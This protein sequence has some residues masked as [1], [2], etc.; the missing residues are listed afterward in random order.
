MYIV[1][2]KVTIPRHYDPQ[3]LRCNP[4]ISRS[5]LWPTALSRA[6]IHAASPMWGSP[7]HAATTAWFWCCNQIEFKYQ[8]FE[9]TTGL[10]HMNSTPPLFT[11]ASVGLPRQ[12]LNLLRSWG[13][14][15]RRQHRRIWY[16][17]FVE[18]R[19]KRVLEKRRER[20]RGINSRTWGTE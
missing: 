11:P 13:G 16:D 17:R 8:C 18:K 14:K 15:L 19:R 6:R 7:L 3:E 12:R 20:T 5:T 10:N 9:R 1:S 2:A 4:A